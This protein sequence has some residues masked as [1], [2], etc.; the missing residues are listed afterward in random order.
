MAT[1]RAL[2]SDHDP[3]ADVLY[4]S[5]GEPVPAYGEHLDEDIVL[6][7]ACDD[8]R[9]VGIT[10]IG[11]SQRGGV[12]ALIER[13]QRLVAELRIPL[14]VERAEKLREMVAPHSLS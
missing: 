6:R 13:L 11:F 5:F 1:Q 10:A 3:D 8:D 2:N 9:I 12:D 4:L 7:H 14:I